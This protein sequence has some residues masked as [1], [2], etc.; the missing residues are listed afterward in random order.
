MTKL[1]LL[2]GSGNRSIHAHSMIFGSQV[3]VR[4][5]HIRYLINVQRYSLW[6]EICTI[7]TSKGKNILR[8]QYNWLFFPLKQCNIEQG[9]YLLNTVKLYLCSQQGAGSKIGKN[10][11][12]IP[13]QKMVHYTQVMSTI[14][15]FMKSEL[16]I[17]ISHDM[18]YICHYILLGQSCN[19]LFTGTVCYFLEC[20]SMLY[21]K[22]NQLFFC[23]PLGH[24]TDG[25]FS[26]TGETII[27]NIN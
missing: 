5:H 9:S 4:G 11:M 10:P 13:A 26:H 19:I 12:K 21:R 20:L 8:T 1:K 7:M 23:I 14:C 17:N 18:C 16:I 15:S 27:E 24:I 6:S 3:K 22:C 2:L 25:K